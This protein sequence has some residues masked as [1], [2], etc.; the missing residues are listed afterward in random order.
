MEPEILLVI[1]LDHWSSNSLLIYIVK[2]FLNHV[3]PNEF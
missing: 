1:G 2:K 3:F